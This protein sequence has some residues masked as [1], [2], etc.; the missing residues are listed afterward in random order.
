MVRIRKNFEH[1]QSPGIV[2]EEASLTQQ[3]FKDECDIDCILKRYDS[4]GFL[5]DPLAVRRPV[6]FGDFSG[7]EDYQAS[8]N[9]LSRIQEYFDGLPAGLRL[10]FGNDP[11]QLVAFLADERNS[12]EAVKLGLL[13]RV[14]PWSS[15]KQPPSV[16]QPAE[17]NPQPA[18]V[19]PQPA[20][21]KP[22]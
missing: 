3:H 12:E 2:F 1:E 7:V 5:V 11:A 21:E 13:E 15:E 6:Q 22:V 17:A 8:M 20:E 16:S 18:E 19:N 4:T 14:D 9:R 10:R